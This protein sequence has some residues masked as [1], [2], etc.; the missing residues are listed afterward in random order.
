MLIAAD[1]TAGA[2]LG[3]ALVEM[4]ADPA[5]AHVDIHFAKQGCFAAR[6]RRA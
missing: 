5:A 3:P 6:A 2:T 1:L 4:L